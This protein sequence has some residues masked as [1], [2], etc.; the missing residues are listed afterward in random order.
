MRDEPT[1]TRTKR[2]TCPSVAAIVLL[3]ASLVTCASAASAQG[4]TPPSTTEAPRTAAPTAGE[5]PLYAAML[6]EA[7]RLAQSPVPRPSPEQEHSW[8]VRHPVLVGTLIGTAGGAVLART[9]AVGGANHDPRVILLGTGVG[10]W[11][12]LIA[13]AVHKAHAKE[14]VG[15]GTKIG[16]AAGAISLV[17]LP[18][19][20][21]YGAGGCGGVS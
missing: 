12:G 18:L 6:R 19:L 2:A 13:S 4:S 10:A 17:V 3:T 15:V 8:V 7:T 5:A 1:R 20:A 9:R 16:I 21:C 14:K 11:G